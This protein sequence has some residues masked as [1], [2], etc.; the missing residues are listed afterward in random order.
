MQKLK[1]ISTVLIIWIVIF[2]LFLIRFDASGFEAFKRVVNL[3]FNYFHKRG[4][5]I[6]TAIISLLLTVSLTLSI[7]N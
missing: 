3:D 1:F 7:I 4:I 6:L 2:I 5:L